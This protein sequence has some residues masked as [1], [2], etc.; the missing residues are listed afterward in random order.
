MRPVFG[1]LPTAA[2]VCICCFASACT[3]ESRVDPTAAPVGNTYKALSGEQV[4]ESTLRG[5]LEAV[6]RDAAIALS[7][8]DLRSAVFQALQASQYP[9]HKLRFRDFLSGDGQYLVAAMSR[10]RVDQS[11]TAANALAREKELLNGLIDLE[12]YMPVAD[13]RAV[14]TGGDNLLVA[15]AIHDREAP[16]GFDLQGRRVILSPG[17]PPATPTLVLVPVETNF[18]RPPAAQRSAGSTSDF[19]PTAAVVTHIW[20]QSPDSYEGWSMGQPEFEIHAFKKHADG[21]WTDDVC[22]GNDQ[23]GS[24]WFDMN[25][26]EYSQPFEIG[27]GDFLANPGQFTFQM[28][29]DDFDSCGQYDGMPPHASAST[30]GALEEV[31][32][33]TYKYEGAIDDL[34]ELYLFFLTQTPLGYILSGSITDDFVGRINLAPRLRC[35]RPDQAHG[36]VRFDINGLNSNYERDG[37]IEIDFRSGTRKPVCDFEAEIVGPNP[38]WLAS[39]P[40]PQPDYLGRYWGRVGSVASEWKDN[41]VVVSNSE[42]YSIPTPLSAGWHL[43][44]LRLTLGAE[45]AT[46]EL[47]VEVR[48]PPPP[49]SPPPPPECANPPCMD[50]VAPLRPTGIRRSAKPA[51]VVPQRAR[52]LREEARLPT[53]P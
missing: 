47:W 27:W 22:S 41:G 8:P 17:A 45:T 32:K 20:L 3:Q 49:P 14:W 29:E 13:H 4:D 26:Q 39:D 33:A 15:T 12:F 50:Q 43:L 19:S 23:V 34:R 44:E 2:T 16:V 36:S 21:V 52:S 51:R 53:R 6:T 46:T 25:G 38:L 31:E 10:A 42:T 1:W 7:E 11:A 40:P 37:W 35:F 9:E 28:W 24:G 18:D 5:R 48:A 30:A